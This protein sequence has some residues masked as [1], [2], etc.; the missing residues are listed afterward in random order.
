[1]PRGGTGLA[2]KARSSEAWAPPSN[3]CQAAPSPSYDQ[4]RAYE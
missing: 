1:M 2:R 4:V 3:A